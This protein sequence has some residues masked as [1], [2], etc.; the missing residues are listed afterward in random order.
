MS[1]RAFVPAAG[2]VLLLGL[3]AAAAL[4]ETPANAR[5]CPSTSVVGG[6]LG[7]RV[8]A[9]SSTKTTYAKSCMYSTGTLVPVKVGF[10]EDTSS[11]FATSEKAAGKLVPLTVIHGL[12]AAAWATKLPGELQVFDGHGTTIKI[13]APLVATAKLEALARKLV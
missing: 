12:G 3:F 7:V 9:P 10:Q 1:R 4:A 8:K 13:Q 5:S 6:A 11:T 2:A